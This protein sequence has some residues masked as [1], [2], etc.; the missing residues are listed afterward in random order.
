MTA[1]NRSSSPGERRQGGQK[2]HIR[3]MQMSWG[4]QQDRDSSKKIAEE[5][6][7]A[8]AG[9]CVC[10]WEAAA[11]TAQRGTCTGCVAPCGC[12]PSSRRIAAQCVCVVRISKQVWTACL[13]LAAIFKLSLSHT[14][15]PNFHSPAHSFTLLLPLSSLLCLLPERLWLKSPPKNAIYTN[16]AINVCVCACVHYVCSACVRLTR[17]CM[18]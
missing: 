11:A 7:R 3:I 15:L 5:R 18:L 16:Y 8:R 1:A 12:P 4:R 17:V 6:G 9:T 13:C 14:R 10:V 2:C